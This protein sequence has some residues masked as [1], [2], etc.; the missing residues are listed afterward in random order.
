MSL[1]SGRGFRFRGLVFYSFQAVLGASGSHF[2][3]SFFKSLEGC[4]I[5]RRLGGLGII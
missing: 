1:V 5:Q 2:P 3:V 4:G